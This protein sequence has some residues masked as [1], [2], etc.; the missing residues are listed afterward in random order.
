MTLTE[1]VVALAILTVIGSLVFTAFIAVNRAS[2][3]LWERAYVENISANVQKCLLSQEREKALSFYL[4][5]G[6]IKDETILYYD[7]NFCIVDDPDKAK[8]L[9]T[10]ANYDTEFN[11]RLENA[12]NELLYSEAFS[13]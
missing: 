8:Y 6:E 12:D 7:G 13:K 5:C 4:A 9:L 10:V 11:I 3:S 2:S 1:V